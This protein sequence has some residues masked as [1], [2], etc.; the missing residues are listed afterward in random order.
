MSLL[1]F[2]DA[3]NSPEIGIGLHQN[4]RAYLGHGLS[5]DS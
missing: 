1:K 3:K 4:P 2:R 5:R